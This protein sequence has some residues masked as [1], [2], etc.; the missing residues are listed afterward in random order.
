MM[1]PSVVTVGSLPVLPVAHDD[2]NPNDSGA[3]DTAQFRAHNS[4]KAVRTVN[5]LAL[6]AKYDVE[7]KEKRSQRTQRTAIPCYFIRIEPSS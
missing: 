1:C 5:R 3:R 4:R 2:S 7:G 6:A